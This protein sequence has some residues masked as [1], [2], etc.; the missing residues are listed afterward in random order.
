MG[1]IFF[2]KSVKVVQTYFVIGRI[3]VN[4]FLTILNF[5]NHKKTFKI[6]F[7]LAQGL[8]SNRI[9]SSL[10]SDLKFKEIFYNWDN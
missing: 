4:I 7:K 2:R 5:I 9:L 1:K 3:K 8:N 6:L 10:A